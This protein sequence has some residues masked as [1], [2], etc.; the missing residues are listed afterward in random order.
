MS[1]V[2]GGVNKSGPRTTVKGGVNEFDYGASIA[3]ISRAAASI[4]MAAAAWRAA[5]PPKPKADRKKDRH[6]IKS[7]R[8]SDGYMREYM[9]RRRA[10]QKAVR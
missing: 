3:A 4:R 6:L 8:H 7:D 2:K 10:A 1:S 9:R 5:N